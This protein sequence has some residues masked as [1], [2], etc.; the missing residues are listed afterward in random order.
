V[1]F[2]NDLYRNSRKH[3][4]RDG[5]Y[6]SPQYM[7]EFEQHNHHKVVDMLVK[8]HEKLGDHDIEGECIDC[9]L[10]TCLRCR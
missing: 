9:G 3:L 7:R 10:G 6:V 8:L 4:Q 2:E 1:C 5:K